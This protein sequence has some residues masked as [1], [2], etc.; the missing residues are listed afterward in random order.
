MK[1]STTKGKHGMQWI[2]QNQLDDLDFADDLTLLSHTHEQM[3][4]KTTSVAAAS[5]SVGLNMHNGKI[6]IR[7]TSTQSHLMEKL[8]KM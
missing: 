1:T 2:A 3:R 6:K 5:L 8:W 4:M 7:R